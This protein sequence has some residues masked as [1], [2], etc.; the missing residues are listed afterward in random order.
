MSFSIL[1]LITTLVISTRS[2]PAVNKIYDYFDETTTAF[3]I[4]MEIDAYLKDKVAIVTGASSGIGKE[5]VRILAMAG[6]KV[7]MASPNQKKNKRARGD[8]IH[9]VLVHKEHK[10]T[11]QK[12]LKNIITK[13]LDLGS[14][15]SILDF[16]KDI[17]V[18]YPEP[19]DF[20]FN[21]AG[22]MAI[23]EFTT[24]SDG[25]EQQFG[26]NYLGHYYLSR[27]LTNKLIQ[28]G[29][30]GNKKGAGRV[31]TVSSTAHQRAPQPFSNV[32]AHNIPPKED[33]YEGWKNYGLSKVGN[34]LF[35][36]ELQ[37]RE[38]PRGLISVSLHPGVIKTELQRFL[39]DEYI[40]SKTFDKSI[41]QG[42]AT[43]IYCALIPEKQLV[44]GGYYDDCNLHMD[45]LRDDIKETDGFYDKGFDAAHTMEYKLWEKSE[46]LI[47]DKGFPFEFMVEHKSPKQ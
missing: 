21:N 17:Y 47:L 44:A 1:F 23:P 46:K 15:E 13:T 32:I 27:L 8:I 2:R 29:G 38:G 24:T 28:H 7:I 26:V 41:E 33:T 40:S 36:R 4:F 9:G 35:A 39:T 43:Q 25:F 45:R 19:I 42:A 6:C 16:V 14:L 11:K 10:T 20:L 18:D 37:R 34:I 22:L 30:A 3:N 12:L 31:I 5:T